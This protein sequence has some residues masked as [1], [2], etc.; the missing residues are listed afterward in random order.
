MDPREFIYLLFGN[1]AAEVSA[2]PFF[3]A[4]EATAS[5][6]GENESNSYKFRP[7]LRTHERLMWEADQEQARYNSDWKKEGTLT[8]ARYV[9][10]LTQEDERGTNRSFDYGKSFAGKNKCS[11]YLVDICLRSGFRSPIMKSVRDG[12]S[13]WQGADTGSIVMAVKNVPAANAGTL[14]EAV[15]G[16]GVDSTVTWAWRIDRLLN[17]ILVANAASSQMLILG[18][19]NKL[20]SE[21]GRC[22][23]VVYR[24]NRIE[25]GDVMTVGHSMVV[26]RFVDWP[27]SDSRGRL[28]NPSYIELSPT[29]GNGLKSFKLYTRMAGTES[30]ATDIN[31]SQAGGDTDT[32]DLKKYIY[33]FELHPGGDPGTEEG[34]ED[35]NVQIKNQDLM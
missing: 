26:D 19:L 28:V 7:P 18:E 33:L 5:P 30:G 8:S 14:R 6:S 29:L 20:M 23:V 21:Q 22:L 9:D 27:F 12:V 25:D 32:A 16:D 1:E 3:L 35:L 11:T 2:N 4:M 34:L 15:M 17:S 10:R 31:H 13:R 24:Q